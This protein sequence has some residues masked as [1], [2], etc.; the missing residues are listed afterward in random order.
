MGGGQRPGPHIW[1]HPGAA[2]A[3]GAQVIAAG[4]LAVGVSSKP[5]WDRGGPWKQKKQEASNSTDAWDKNIEWAWS[6]GR[7]W[8]RPGCGGQQG[9]PSPGLESSVALTRPMAVPAW[10]GVEVGA[11]LGELRPWLWFC[12]CCGEGFSLL[13]PQL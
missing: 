3:L 7:A 5:G 9:S 12:S 2:A 11:L 4:C 6:Q 13:S 8:E 10:H 1:G